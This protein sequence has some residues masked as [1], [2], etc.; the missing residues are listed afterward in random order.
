MENLLC[1]QLVALNCLMLTPFVTNWCPVQKSSLWKQ[2]K[3][4]VT[5]SV[6]PKELSIT[7]RTIL[8]PSE[9]FFLPN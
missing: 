7:H 8:N 6:N 3:V 4:H 1:A 2:F 9:C 5:I